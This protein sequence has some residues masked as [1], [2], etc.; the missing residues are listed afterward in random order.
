MITGIKSLTDAHIAGERR[1]YS[2][3]K[4]SSQTTT[5]GLWF[6]LALSPGNPPPKY[7][8]DASPLTARAITQSADGGFYHGPNVSP[9][10]KYL[11]KLLT[12]M[13]T[14]TPLP[15]SMVLCDYVMYY[16][17]IDEGNTDL[18]E[19]DNTVTLP[20]HT[21]GQG[22]QI[23]PVTVGA[24]TVSV[25]FS[26]SYTNSDGVAGRTSVITTLN[27]AS[28]IGTV[29][30]SATATSD[31]ANP[32]LGLQSGDSGVRSIQSVQM[33]GSG[34]GLFSLILVKPLATTMC[35]EITA[36]TEI[37]MLGNSSILPI[38]PD[39][40]FLSYLCLPNGSLSGVLV[41]GDL[42]VVWS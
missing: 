23:L 28:A 24:R 18:Q 2:Y 6:D 22:L 42:E 30:S 14:A 15:M 20:R 10:T 8:F 1:R 39:N 35:R 21:S 9:D 33:L 36:P 31:A 32:F 12:V 37:D 3:R 7:W 17:S 5:A 41:T 26:V 29:A 16:P 27:T 11:T 4:V 13:G 38:I 34:D 40:A 19:L 25:T